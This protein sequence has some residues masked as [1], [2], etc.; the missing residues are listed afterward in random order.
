MTSILC[1]RETMRNDIDM[2]MVNQDNR[3]GQHPSLWP[4]FRKP[5]CA[6][7]QGW[8]IHVDMQNTT[9]SNGNQH[10]LFQFHAPRLKDFNSGKTRIIDSANQSSWD[11]V[12]KNSQFPLLSAYP[13]WRLVI[14]PWVISCHNSVS[15]NE[16]GILWVRCHLIFQPSPAPPH[17]LYIHLRWQAG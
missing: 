6:V 16:L 9:R 17:C 14:K 13:A 8:F 7:D 5:P 11:S 10:E 12:L 2:P 1:H 3:P 4:G 15:T